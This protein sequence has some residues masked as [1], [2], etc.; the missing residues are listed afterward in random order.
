MALSRF[1]GS[2]TGPS[3]SAFVLLNLGISKLLIVQS[4]TIGEV[5]YSDREVA[6][7]PDTPNAIEILAGSDSKSSVEERKG[8]P[9][10]L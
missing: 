5:F 9:P 7:N 1:L 4:D 6:G 10:K 3:P 2:R 8:E